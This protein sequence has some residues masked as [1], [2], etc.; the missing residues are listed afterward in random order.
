M[1]MCIA[2]C[3][4]IADSRRTKQLI[5]PVFAKLEVGSKPRVPLGRINMVIDRPEIVE[6]LKRVIG[7]GDIKVDEIT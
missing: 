3:I 7:F 5:S 4:P 2:G 6:K 1:V